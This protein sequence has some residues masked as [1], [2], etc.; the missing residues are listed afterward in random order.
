[1]AVQTEMFSST[2]IEDDV[3]LMVLVLL[4][5]DLSLFP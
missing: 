5:C 1:L 3:M 2:S 4:V